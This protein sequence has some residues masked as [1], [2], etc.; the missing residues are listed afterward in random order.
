[1]DLELNKK[2]VLIT[3]GS[4]GIGLATAETFA[5]EGANL[6]LVAR[7]DKDLHI[8]KT[9]LSSRYDVNI[10]TISADL[11]TPTSIETLA[12]DV[13]SVDIIINNAGAIPPGSLFDLTSET[14]RRAWDLKVHGYIDLTRALYAKLT[15]PDGVIVNIIGS[16]GASPN[17]DYI[18]GS[19]GNAALMMFTRS[20]AQQ[21]RAD[22]VRVVGINPGPVLTDRFRMLLQAEAER[23]YSDA[24]R[25]QDL[26]AGLP[27][28]RAAA[29]EEIG[30]AVAFLASPRSAYTTGTIVT[31]DG[32]L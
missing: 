12:R 10:Q 13:N 7:T 23:Q 22:G 18:C 25:W 26:M 14:W 17:K 30:D 8:A 20:F 6:I 28:G 2:Q 21:A 5:R 11:A 1:M 27:F 19:T 16:A 29:P 31:I 3:G 4:K 24:S 9:T 15:K 32:G